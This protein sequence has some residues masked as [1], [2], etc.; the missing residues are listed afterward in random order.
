MDETDAWHL[1]AG[2]AAVRQEDGVRLDWFGD[3]FGGIVYGFQSYR[4]AIKVL[5]DSSNKESGKLR[6]DLF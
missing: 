1:R 3:W 2:R 4:R 6:K 5:G